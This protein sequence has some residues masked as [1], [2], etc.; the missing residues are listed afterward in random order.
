MLEL[1][2]ENAIKNGA[3]DWY[4]PIKHFFFITTDKTLQY[5]TDLL[6]AIIG[7]FEGKLII[8]ELRDVTCN[9]YLP[10]KE[11]EWILQNIEGKKPDDQPK[12]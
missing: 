6:S 3:T 4:E 7:T 2:V 8:V 1:T 12:T 5:W 9:G 10:T 11:W